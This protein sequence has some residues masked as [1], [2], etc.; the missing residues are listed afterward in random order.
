MDFD[1]SDVQDFSG[2]ILA[3]NRKILPG[4]DVFIKHNIS[5][6]RSGQLRGIKWVGLFV[7]FHDEH[8]GDSEHFLINDEYD[9][10][11]MRCRVKTRI[12]LYNEHRLVQ[13][14]DEVAYTSQPLLEHTTTDDI[15]QATENLVSSFILPKLLE[16]GLPISKDYWRQG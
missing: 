12:A 10:T 7:W 2:K 16:L 13:P 14:F 1:P 15:M 9:P 11:F 5:D 4:L 6:K 3:S 8:V